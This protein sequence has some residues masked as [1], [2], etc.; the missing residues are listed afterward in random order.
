MIDPVAAGRTKLSAAEIAAVAGSTP[1]RHGTMKHQL[2][3]Q[4]HGGDAKGAGRQFLTLN[5]V[6]GK[7][8]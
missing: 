1:I 4:D 5:T 6:T 3:R 2:A 8:L 7:D